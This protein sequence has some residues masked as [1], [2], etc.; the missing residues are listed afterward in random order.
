[1]TTTSNANKFNISGSF[2]TCDICNHSND[3][4]RDSGHRFTREQREIVLKFKRLHLQQQAQ[5]RQHL[6]DNILKC[7]NS[8]D[9]N[10]RPTHGLIYSD[11]M[12]AMRGDT[13]RFGRT[14]KS[15]GDCGAQHVGNRVIGVEVYCGPVDC[16]FLYH[17]DNIPSGGANIMIEIQRQAMIDLARILREEHSME[18]P[19]HM[20][21]QFDN[22]G[23]NKVSC[24]CVVCVCVCLCVCVCC[25]VCSCAYS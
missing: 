14:R 8:R 10:G 16:V 6:A 9:R 22:C 15:K 11:G 18:M 12:T 1:V 17:T 2:E 21:F 20:M 24:V 3:L 13:P 7:K 23:E 19:R 5:E 25:C 4:L